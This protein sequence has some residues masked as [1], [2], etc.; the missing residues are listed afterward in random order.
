MSLVQHLREFIRERLTAA[1]EEIFTEFE[2]TIVLFEKEIDRHRRLLDTCKKKAQI[3]FHTAELPQQ[4]H[5]CKEEEDVPMDQQPSDHERDRAEPEPPQIKDIKIKF[6]TRQEV[7][8]LLLKKEADSFPVR[9]GKSRCEGTSAASENSI[10][11]FKGGLDGRRRPT[12]INFNTSDPLQQ[13]PA[14]EEDLRD[15]QLL[16]EH[17]RKSSLDREL[18][19]RVSHPNKEEQENPQPP[20][21]KED[22]EEPEL[23][24]IKQEQEEFCSSPDEELALLKEETNILVIN[25][26][27]SDSSKSEPSSTQ[28]LSHSSA[29]SPLRQESGL[30]TGETKTFVCNTCGE[31]F[32][33]LSL[34]IFHQK[35]HQE[36]KLFSCE[37]CLK[38]F[39]RRG[40][41]L[42]HM[43]TH[44][45]ERPFCCQICGDTFGLNSHL[46]RHM[47]TH[48]GEKPFTCKV[49]HKSFTQSN[50]LTYHMRIH[51]GEKPHSCKECGKG[52]IQTGALRVHMRTHTNEKPYSCNVC[53]KSLRSSTSLLYHMRTHTGEKP[54]SCKI[55]LKRFS[56][57]NH[58]TG[59]MRIHTGEK[60]Y[61]CDECGKGF[62]SPSTLN[63]HISTHRGEKPFGCNRCGKSL[64]SR[65]SLLY[66]MRTH[67]GERPYSCK[68]CS[69]RF[70]QSSHLFSH[71]KCS[72]R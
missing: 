58:L 21:I 6:W 51:T 5:V 13:H 10:V 14:E 26:D 22:Q 39:S 23:I 32:S 41:L 56:Q 34:M 64:G 54:Y 57:S 47:R 30:E 19:T 20:Q 29:S 36:E 7:E 71:M 40:S 18:Q 11:H 70:S 2:K 16:R 17:D 63:T 15:N 49:C 65:T 8:H 27:E 62:V 28:L 3:N 12:Q 59:H 43:I 44:T 38:T 61:H 69:K 24:Q 67:T 25:Y 48:T 9:R 55:C 37:T 33:D 68:I 35:S 46:L 66:H 60:P 52:F 45:G 31:K 1:V 72:H 50:S 4:Q 42:R 53:G